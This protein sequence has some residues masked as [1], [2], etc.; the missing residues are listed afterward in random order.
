MLRWSHDSRRPFSAESTLYFGSITR[1][2]ETTRQA[3]LRRCFLRFTLARQAF[4]PAPRECCVARGV[5]IERIRSWVAGRGRLPPF[6]VSRCRR[7]LTARRAPF[8]RVGGRKDP[9]ATP[10]AAV[11]ARAVVAAGAPLRGRRAAARRREASRL[12]ELV[13][14]G[15][16]IGGRRDRRRRLVHRHT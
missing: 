13:P 8:H 5:P 12:V 1:S 2:H 16:R 6:S 14:A 9:P 3:G 15:G 11:S 7:A 10:R 4:R